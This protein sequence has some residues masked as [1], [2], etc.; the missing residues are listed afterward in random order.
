M[1]AASACGG[2]GSTDAPSGPSTPSSSVVVSPA[3]MHVAV[4]GTA[5]ISAQLLDS[6]KSPVSGAAFTFTSS[7]QAVATVSASGLVNGV[8][9][10]TATITA[11]SGGFSAN[12]TAQ[13]VVPTTVIGHVST[14]D[15]GP[16]TGLAATV[17]TGTGY[18]AQDFTGPLDAGGAFQVAAPL[19]FAPADSVRVIIDASPAARR[20]HPTVALAAAARIG[21]SAARPMLVPRTEVFSTPNYPA[22]SVDVSLDAAFRRVCSDDTNANCNSFFPQVWKSAVILW[23]DADLPIPLAFYTTASTSPISAADSVALWATI[24]K[25]QKDLGRTLFK[26]ATLSSLAAPDANGYSA[27]AV[28]VWVDSTLTGFAGYTNW[29][30]DA[31]LNMLAAKTRVTRNSAL[32]STGLMTHE[33]LHALGFHHT[34][35]WP[36]VMGGY[37]CQEQSG[38]TKSDA[39]AFNL[40]YAIRDAIRA[41]APTT[42]LADA[43]RGE[44]TRELAPVASR[45][46]TAIAPG[47]VVF[48]PRAPRQV[49][50]GGRLVSADGA[51]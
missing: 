2:S 16:S 19:T 33:L 38:A 45:S 50:F 4:G 27:K 18:G 40:G 23:S 28:L 6:A 24:D 49:L 13:V 20:Y 51:P 30:W 12:T 42:T 22:S 5:Q 43:L 36:T 14:V 47:P 29:I 37:G 7:D 26:P 21:A 10:G 3:P 34:C 1:V 48:A 25:M 46:G 11:T 32:A 44:Q 9:A 17:E 39:A 31:N 35:A 8:R 41:N 15:A